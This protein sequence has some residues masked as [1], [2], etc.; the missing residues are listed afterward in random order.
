MDGV[1]VG[2]IGAITSAYVTNDPKAPARA[3]EINP[4]IDLIVEEVKVLDPQCD[5]LVLLCHLGSK[6]CLNIAERVPQIDVFLS[7]HSHERLDV[8]I[9]SEASGALILQTGAFASSIGRLDLTVD[10][11]EKRI[12]E[13]DFELV[14]LDHDTTPLDKELANWVAEREQEVCPQA[15]VVLGHAAREIRGRALAQMFA[16]AIRAKSGAEIAVDSPNMLRATLPAGPIE[17]NTVFKAYIPGGRAAVSKREA[18][19][20][21]IKGADL[22]DYLEKGMAKR[23]AP[24]WVGFAAKADYQKP[25]GERVLFSDLEP[26]RTYQV[27]LSRVMLTA[28]AT[29]IGKKPEAFE[30]KGLEFNVIDAMA[31]KIQ[32]M[33]AEGAEIGAEEAAAAAN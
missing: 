7:G 29:A 19:L 16:D 14:A 13:S 31:E 18:V 21:S 10:L 12:V 20:I 22:L 32:A 3:L 24:A 6:A 33:A 2:V 28:L 17:Y 26:G 23:G 30:A 4:T 27:A 1:K 25:E 9:V 8:P 15:A 11:G 5:L